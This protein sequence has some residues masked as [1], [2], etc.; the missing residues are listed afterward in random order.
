MPGTERNTG[1]PCFKTEFTFGKE[2]P[3]KKVAQ[4]LI[5]F[6]DNCIWIGSIN[7]F[8]NGKEMIT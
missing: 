1:I 6:R 8:W 4:A 2:I 7:Q 3:F 5:N